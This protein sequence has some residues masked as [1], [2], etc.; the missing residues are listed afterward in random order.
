MFQTLLQE[1]RHGMGV[2]AS[3]LLYEDLDKYSEEMNWPNHAIRL[4]N[5]NNTLIDIVNNVFTNFRSS[6]YSN[7]LREG[8]L[9]SDITGHIKPKDVRNLIYK[10]TDS[11]AIDSLR[12]ELMND[13]SNVVNNEKRLLE[14]LQNGV[15]R[16]YWEFLIR[17]I[18]NSLDAASDDIYGSLGAV[19][20]SRAVYK[21]FELYKSVFSRSFVN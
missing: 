6:G 14:S 10:L 18:Y 2:Y 3:Q 13:L 11:S 17:R 16:T 5:A 15:G 19:T 9:R 21:Y 12:V 1:F 4:P 8:T 20:V 7:S